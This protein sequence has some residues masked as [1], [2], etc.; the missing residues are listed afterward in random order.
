M[1]LTDQCLCGTITYKLKNSLAMTGV[2]H[3]KSCQRQVGSSFSTLAG[4]AK[5]DFVLKSGQMKI[6]KDSETDTGNAVERHFC[7]EC[8]SPIYSAIPDS[9]DVL[10]I[11]TGSMDDT[12][13]FSPQFYV[14]SSSKQDWV[15]LE[16]GVPAM[17]KTEG[18]L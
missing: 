10:F 15:E 14:R 16:E 12:S 7:G 9:P 17:Q 6:Y 13:Y 18:L 4:I 2:C 8:G 3:C 11:K 1:S 5:T